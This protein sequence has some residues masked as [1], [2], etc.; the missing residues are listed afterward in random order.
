MYFHG[1]TRGGK[2]HA[3][4]SEETP[5]RHASLLVFCGVYIHDGWSEGLP[6]PSTPGLCSN[7]SRAMKK[8]AAQVPS[9]NSQSSGVNSEH[10]TVPVGK[11]RRLRGADP[12]GSVN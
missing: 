1:K 9:Q 5:K 7:C 8:R 10:H 3:G 6:D 4:Q 12:V 11:R 2:T